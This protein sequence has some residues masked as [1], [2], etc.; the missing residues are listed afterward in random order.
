MSRRIQFLG[1]PLAYLL[2]AI[3]MTWPL[4]SDLGGILGGGLDPL[5]QSWV[6]AW[7]SHSLRTNPLGI[8]QAPIFFPYPDTLAFSDH[9]ILLA[10]ITAPIYWLSGN[11]AIA[12]NLLVLMS[13]TLSGWAVYLLAGELWGKQNRRTGCQTQKVPRPTAEPLNQEPRTAEPRTKNQPAMQPITNYQL[14]SGSILTPD[15]RTLSA[16]AAGA[17][18][19]FCAFRMAQFVHLQMLQTAWMVLAL[20]FLIRTIRTA[21]WCDGLLCGLFFGVQCVTALYFAYIAAVLLGLYIALWVIRSLWNRIR[22]N[23]RLPWDVLIRLVAGGGVAAA[24]VV[25]FSMPYIR[26]YQS[27][28]VVRSAQE[29]ENWSAPLQAYIAVAPGNRILGANELFRAPGGEFALFPGLVVSVLALVGLTEPQNRRTAEPSTTA[30]QHQERSALLANQLPSWMSRSFLMLLAA[31]GFI[32]SLGIVLRLVRGGEPLPIPLPYGVLYER[33]P[34]FG[35]LRVPAR[36]GI[37]VSLSACLLAARGLLVVIRSGDQQTRRPAD[38]KLQHVGKGDSAVGPEGT[39]LRNSMRTKSQIFLPA[40]ALLFILAES[41]TVL[42]FAQAPDLRAAPAVYSWLA[43]PAQA[44]IRAVLELPASRTQRGEELEQSMRRQYYGLLHWKP[45]VT[46][47]SGLIPFGTTDILGRVQQLPDAQAIQFLQVAGI[48]TLVLHRSEYEPAILQKLITGLDSSPLV[49][50]RAEVGNTLVY[51]ILP[52]AGRNLPAGSTVL[53]TSDERAP[54][55]PALAL[56]R[57]WAASGARLYGAARV[58]YYAALANPPVGQVFDYA[59]LADSEDPQAYGYGQDRQLWRAAGLALYQRDPALLLNFKPGVVPTGQF[60]PVY[61]AT[62]DIS[63][64]STQAQINRQQVTWTQPIT[65]AVVQLEIASLTTQQIETPVGQI[66]LLPGITNITFPVT[67]GQCVRLVGQI[68][69]TAIIQVQL[70][71]ELPSGQLQPND[72]LAIAA[73]S[74]FAGS[75]LIVDAK[76]GGAGSLLIEV[77]GAA[78]ANDQPILL[79]SGIQPIAPDG[80]AEWSFSTD[81]LRPNEPWLQEAQTAVDGRYIV[82]IKDASH[83]EAPGIPI[84][85]YR[86]RN[87]Q[88]MDAQPVPLPLVELP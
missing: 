86:V 27:I 80:Y 25:P 81:L 23:Q 13:Y 32:L 24:I 83:P 9:H 5:L 87:A 43:A 42:P 61:P 34:G 20:L 54:G 15:P 88:I 82:Y 51:T 53:L 6:L 66:T 74:R 62:L 60:H 57:N 26:V 7:N 69:R 72:R 41:S 4:A 64:Q 39:R 16:F 36:W 59:L 11:P 3:V 8:W 47:Y 46:G 37:L 35:A 56:A 58:R 65:Q 68:D 48:D 38:Q 45:L 77:R 84:A 12:H 85:Q 17:A 55:V 1:I 44:N 67:R 76:A 2:L 30:P 28:G 14:H 49:Q 21:T 40:L 18:F 50:Q 29:L 63:L 10:A 75:R 52:F 31:I 73:Q 79:L 70:R 33:L 78:A 19:A 71:A 22:H